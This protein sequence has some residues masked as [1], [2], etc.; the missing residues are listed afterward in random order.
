LVGQ[1]V[2]K[3]LEVRDVM[4]FGRSGIL[5][6]VRIGRILSP[7]INVFLQLLVHCVSYLSGDYRTER[8]IQNIT[9]VLLGVPIYI[10][11]SIYCTFVH[12]V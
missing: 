7:V 11:I 3:S 8:H 9:F 5:E 1:G 10:N 2:Q 4:I 12:R 6:C